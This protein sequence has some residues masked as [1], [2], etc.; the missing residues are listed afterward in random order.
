MTWQGPL[1]PHCNASRQ[2]GGATLSLST[3]SIRGMAPTLPH[4]RRF[5]VSS[6]NGHDSLTLDP[7]AHCHPLEGYLLTLQPPYGPNLHTCYS[8]NRLWEQIVTLRCNG[9]AS[10]GRPAPSLGR[11]AP[12][13]PP[14]PLYYLQIPP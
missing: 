14:P 2:P 10:E 4:K 3:S 8:G 13:A 11:P 5:H 9:G 1:G 6:S 12:K 7:W